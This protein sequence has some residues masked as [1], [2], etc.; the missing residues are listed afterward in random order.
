MG[1]LRSAIR[2]LATAGEGP[3]RLLERL[4]GFVEHV[5]TAQM[6]TVAY[7][8]LDLRSGRARYAC[9][10]HP[11]PVLVQPGQPAEL[12]W[13]GRGTP[14]GAWSGRGSRTEDEV[15]LAPGA[16]LLLFTDGLVERRRTS[17]T[18]RLELLVAEVEARRG[19]PPQALVRE[20]TA[21][22]LRDAENADDVCL[23]LLARRDLSPLLLTL[24]PRFERL[25][26]MRRELRRWL[27][28]VGVEGDDLDAV[29]LAASEAA[30]NAMEHGC[31]GV[32]DDAE[33][34]TVSAHRLDGA[35]EVVVRDP[36]L[37]RPPADAPDVDIGLPP[38]SERGRGLFLM[39]RLM[40]SVEVLTG[41]GTQVVLRRKVPAAVD[42]CA[43]GPEPGGAGAGP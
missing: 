5:E 6:A 4:D 21:T 11:P 32:A 25:A 42:P 12:V 23:L 2:A 36:G 41:D 39:R 3:A 29:V 14:L 10:G 15:E 20:V 8:E 28:R 43:L 37:W 38:G 13:G 1:Q 17:L 7:L 33:P 22:L 18:D 24:P 26:A 19:M 16:Q 31:R 34:V 35:V 30:A 27:E 9:A 40:D